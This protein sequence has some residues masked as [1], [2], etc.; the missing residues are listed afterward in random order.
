MARETK[1]GLLVGMCVILLIGIIVSDHLSVVNQQQPAPLIGFA[2]D[3]QRGVNSRPAEAAANTPADAIN[4]MRTTERSR[5]LPMPGEGATSTIRPPAPTGGPGAPSGPSFPV[6]N[7][8]QQI[9]RRPTPPDTSIARGPASPT[10]TP[11]PTPGP[12]ALAQHTVKHGE[13]LYSIA[14][15][16]YGKTSEWKRI[17]EANASAVGPQG[18]LKDSMNLLIPALPGQTPGQTPA[19]AGA[20]A[21]TAPRLTDSG[22][23]AGSTP[24][25]P[26]RGSSRTIRVQPNDTLATLAARH[27]G[28]RDRWLDIL[29]ANKDKLHKA[30]DLKIGME[31]RLPESRASLTPRS[32]I[33]PV[34]GSAGSTATVSTAG[35]SVAPPSRPATLVTGPVRT[36]NPLPTGVRPVMPQPAAG[37]T[38]GVVTPA[39][40]PTASMPPATPVTRPGTPWPGSGPADRATPA[41]AAPAAVRTYTIQPG[42]SLQ[43]IAQQM[44]GD[45]NQWPR[46]F[47]LNRAALAGQQQLRVG[48]ELV[49]PPAS[50]R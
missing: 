8:D 38:S 23:T 25:Q 32:E 2:R 48:Q 28:S 14:K 34:A 12:V 50:S 9:E 3:A 20:P 10:Q 11:T 39:P 16:Y 24:S 44:L 40:R 18:Q 21:P 45:S 6:P 31:L 26:V 30:Q 41:P 22:N 19:Q 36:A 1:V 35:S 15:Q 46:I 37:S 49:I 42:D 43:G 7:N 13:T 27:L 29:E 5:P 33:T 17:Q 4:G 47:D